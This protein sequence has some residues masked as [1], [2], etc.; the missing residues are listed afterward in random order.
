MLIELCLGAWLLELAKSL[1]RRQVVPA[2]CEHAPHPLPHVEAKQLDQT[3]GLELHLSSPA[4]L[5]Q[6]FHESSRVELARGAC[7]GAAH[8]RL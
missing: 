2:L 6:V 8:S 4:Q 5:R 3:L 1:E 7:V